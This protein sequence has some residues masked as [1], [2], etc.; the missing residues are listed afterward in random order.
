MG[1]ELRLFKALLLIMSLWIGVIY[2][3]DICLK[4]PRF[5]SNFKSPISVNHIWIYD[6]NFKLGYQIQPFFKTYRPMVEWGC[7]LLLKFWCVYLTTTSNQISSQASLNWQ[8]NQFTS[9]AL[10]LSA[11]LSRCPKGMFCC[12]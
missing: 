10:L 8:T 4:G 11:D 9:L 6:S 12:I 2:L 1:W 7:W 5:A 3:Y